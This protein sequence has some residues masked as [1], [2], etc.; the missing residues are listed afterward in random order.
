MVFVLLF[1]PLSACAD[2]PWSRNPFRFKMEP[3]KA[4]KKVV[5]KERDAISGLTTIFIRG[6]IKVAVI[7]GREYS[8]GDVL[9]KTIITNITLN[10]VTVKENGKIKIYRLK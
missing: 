3:G 2:D 9:G 5:V 10:S 8:E 6:N 1:P 7:N 4:E